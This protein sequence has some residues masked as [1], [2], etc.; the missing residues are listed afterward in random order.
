MLWEKRRP[1]KVGRAS[2][3]H[4]SLAQPNVVLRE[5]DDSPA[6]EATNT[7]APRCLRR[8]GIAPAARK[9]ADL[10]LT[11]IKCAQSL[12]EVAST[13]RFSMTPAA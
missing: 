7:I 5:V 12:S 8:Y 13:P 4:V 10:R 3:Q 6:I 2:Y 11:S 1:K 9:K